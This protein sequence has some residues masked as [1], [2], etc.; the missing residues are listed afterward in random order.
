MHSLQSRVNFS[1]TEGDLKVYVEG[2]FFEG[3][4]ARDS[5]PDIIL[6]YASAGDVSWQI[7]GLFQQ[8]E[9]DGGTADGESESNFGVTG[10]VNVA[11]DDELLGADSAEEIST[12]HANYRWSPYE[13]VN[14]GVELSQAIELQQR[15][16]L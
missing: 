14:L 4:T 2:D 12:F 10:G 16:N 11:F 13:N 7:A 5:L 15:G 3:E 8:F 9:V 6:R 1:A